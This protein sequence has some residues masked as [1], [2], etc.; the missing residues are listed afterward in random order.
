MRN[1]RNENMVCRALAA[2]AFN[3]ALA[4]SNATAAANISTAV[5]SIHSTRP[6]DDAAAG[7]PIV[8]DEFADSHFSASYHQAVLTQPLTSA[9]KTEGCPRRPVA[10]SDT[11]SLAT[12]RTPRFQTPITWQSGF[13]I[14]GSQAWT[15]VIKF[16]SHGINI[17]LP[18]N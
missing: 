16:S 14:A 17:R 7:G 4:H 18:L 1:R 3:V 12:N 5:A 13:I 15:R 6:I 8:R 11:I 10:A 2:L 9:C